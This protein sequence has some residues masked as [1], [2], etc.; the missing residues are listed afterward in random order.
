MFLGN[1]SEKPSFPLSIY[2]LYNAVNTLAF[3]YADIEITAYE[4]Q[5]QPTP[6]L[7]NLVNFDYPVAYFFLAFRFCG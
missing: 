6:L 4:Q 2:H 5:S 3:I 7:T 1:G